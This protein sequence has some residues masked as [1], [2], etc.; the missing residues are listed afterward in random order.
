[1]SRDEVLALP[2]TIDL[3]T[4]CRALGLG[5][6]LGYQLAQRGEFPCPVLR[7]GR[8]YLVP[9]AGIHAL[10]GL[11]AAR[12][13]SGMADPDGGPEPSRRG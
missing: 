7:I 8:R 3:P 12:P 4:A 11:T 13:E 9:T 2:A 1:M 6:T 5:R 10:L